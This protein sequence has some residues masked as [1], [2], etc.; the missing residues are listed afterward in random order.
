MPFALRQGKNGNSEYELVSAKP[1][2]FQR[3]IVQK[4]GGSE[5]GSFQNRNVLFEARRGWRSG[6]VKVVLDASL[7]TLPHDIELACELL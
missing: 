4:R 5:T 7:L 6:W 3:A 1:K 2:S